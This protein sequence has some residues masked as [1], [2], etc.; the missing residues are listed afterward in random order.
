MPHKGNY[1]GIKP[2]KQMKK[3]AEKMHKQERKV[4]KKKKKKVRTSDGM[5]MI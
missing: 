4:A 1:G 2:T 3:E 5:M